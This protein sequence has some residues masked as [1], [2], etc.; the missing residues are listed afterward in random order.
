MQ[1]QQVNRTDDEKIYLVV[2]NV[3]AVTA[4]TGF[5][6]RYVGGAAAEIVST[7]GANAVFQTD[8]T[9]GLAAGVAVED[10]AVNAYGRVQAYGLVSVAYSFEADKTVGVTGVATSLLKTGGLAGSFTSTRVP[11]GLS[12]SLYK[13]AINMVTTNISGGLPLGSAFIRYL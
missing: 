3:N 11:E 9:N 5:G 13:Y 10:I 8:A 7:G 1:I 4:T 12:T 2:K 6:L